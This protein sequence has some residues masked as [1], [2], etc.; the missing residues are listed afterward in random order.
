MSSCRHRLRNLHRANFVNIYY[1]RVG[2]NSC[3]M[4][5]QEYL[6]VVKL[7]FISHTPR[8]RTGAF[9]DSAQRRSILAPPTKRRSSSPVSIN[10]GRHS[11]HCIS[12]PP[13]AHL[14]LGQ[15]HSRRAFGQDRCV[16]TTRMRVRPS[17]HLGRLSIRTSSFFN[18]RVDSISKW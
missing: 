13:F 11:C 5:K 9:I 2:I 15:Y 14:S 18:V 6:S 12:R 4:T 16:C 8:K 1:K 17:S 10:F 3:T 7:L